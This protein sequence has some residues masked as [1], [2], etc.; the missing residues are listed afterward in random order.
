M[1]AGAITDFAPALPPAKQGGVGNGCVKSVYRYA[2]V[3]SPSR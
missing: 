3:Q 1:A 2:T